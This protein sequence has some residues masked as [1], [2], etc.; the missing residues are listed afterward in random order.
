M[1]IEGDI[2]LYNKNSTRMI[3][4]CRCNNAHF[5][6]ILAFGSKVCQVCTYNKIPLSAKSRMEIEGW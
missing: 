4:Q 1:T 3:S 2:R 6:T 5:R